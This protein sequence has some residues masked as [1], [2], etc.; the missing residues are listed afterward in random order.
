M[1]GIATYLATTRK[2]PGTGLPSE[3]QI[4]LFVGAARDA[5]NDSL[6]VFKLN[7]TAASLKAA[8]DFQATH[9]EL[10]RFQAEYR[11]Q[12]AFRNMGAY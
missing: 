8:K 9:V 11:A 3:K 2:Q 7:P 6:K 12:T 5:A 10:S 1:D 4:S